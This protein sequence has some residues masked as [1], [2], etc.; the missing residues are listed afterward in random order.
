LLALMTSFQM[1][2]RTLAIQERSSEV[3]RTL[4]AV[5]TEFGKFGDVLAKVKSQTETVLNTLN[6]AETRSRAMG[7]VLRQVEALPEA[8]SQALLPADKEADEG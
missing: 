6:S 4:G 2:F 1:G 3:W 8:Q 5:K 7:R